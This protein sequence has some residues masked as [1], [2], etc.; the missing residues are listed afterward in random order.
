MKIMRIILPIAPT[1]ERKFFFNNP[2]L[3]EYDN[4]EV[5]DY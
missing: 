3:S 1:G 2:W 5:D 4:D